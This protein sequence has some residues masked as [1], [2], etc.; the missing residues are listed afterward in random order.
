MGEINKQ[1][2]YYTGTH[3]PNTFVISADARS[4]RYVPKK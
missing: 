4:L 1:G 2:C 3:S